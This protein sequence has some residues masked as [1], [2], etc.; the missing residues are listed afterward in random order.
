MS[1]EARE[2]PFRYWCCNFFLIS[3]MWRIPR[4][5]QDGTSAARCNGMR[6]H[7]PRS[8][9]AFLLTLAAV[10]VAAKLIFTSLFTRFAW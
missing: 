5:S 10:L 2:S 3:E 8:S 6:E 1:P 7:Y 9:M 4:L